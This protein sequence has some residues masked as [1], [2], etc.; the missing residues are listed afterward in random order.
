MDAKICDRCGKFYM[1]YYEKC[2]DDFANAL[3]L[4]VEHGRICRQMD[5]CRNCM[6]KLKKFLKIDPNEKEKDDGSQ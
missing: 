2:N 1:Q 6:T 5:L 3:T 4:H